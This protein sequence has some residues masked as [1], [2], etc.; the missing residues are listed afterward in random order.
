MAF[1]FQ[2]EDQNLRQIF[3]Y[4]NMS[5]D[6]AFLFLPIVGVVRY[7]F[8]LKG[9]V[10]DQFNVF[11]D[12][13]ICCVLLLTFASF[14]TLGMELPQHI[15]KWTNL[16]EVTVNVDPIAGSR[17]SIWVSI[18]CKWTTHACY[19]VAKVIYY[20]S[21]LILCFLAAWVILGVTMTSFF[22]AFVVFV[23]VFLFVCL[24]PT[25]W[26]LVNIGTKLLFDAK[27][28]DWN[29][30]VLVM[31]SIGKAVL[32]WISFK[33]ALYEPFL[34][35][36][37]EASKSIMQKG[38]QT[39]ALASTGIGAT[40]KVLTAF[41]G[42]KYVDGSSNAIKSLKS[43]GLKYSQMTIPT[44]EKLISAAGSKAFKEIH[45]AS[46]KIGSTLKNGVSFFQNKSN[47][48][49]LEKIP[50]SSPFMRTLRSTSTFSFRSGS[51]KSPPS[52][53]TS[54]QSGTSTGAPE[55]ITPSPTLSNQHATLPQSPRKIESA[56]VRT[57]HEPISERL[58]AKKSNLISS[59]AGKNIPQTKSNLPKK[60]SRLPK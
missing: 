24:I 22:S 38:F 8:A 25:F 39:A 42:Q 47:L 5:K 37:H 7:I 34:Q 26:T 14:I 11:K 6:Q 30:S 18:L 31:S 20:V 48:Y 17:F 28:P 53:Q 45:E 58:P 57:P 4:Y 44:A 13:V 32:T 33:K 59:S 3:E 10:E 15:A 19:V 46:P 40:G 16:G 51:I 1:A 60:S 55:V 21:L 49:N 2:L 29:N 23:V 12:V 54:S 50:G 27:D 56:P 9:G 41:G 43:T 35:K 36:F 52:Q